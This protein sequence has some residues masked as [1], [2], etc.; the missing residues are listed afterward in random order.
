VNNAVLTVEFVRVV[1]DKTEDAA[2]KNVAEMFDAMIE[3]ENRFVAMMFVDCRFIDQMFE[4][5]WLGRPMFTG[6]CG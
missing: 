3:N 4:T 5:V 1:F 6:R 2:V